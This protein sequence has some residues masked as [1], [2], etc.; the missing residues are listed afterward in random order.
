M[1]KSSS[2][3]SSSWD[4]SAPSMLVSV[5]GLGGVEWYDWLC[6]CLVSGKPCG[7]DI[8]EGDRME[9]KYLVAPG[10]PGDCAGRAA[11]GECNPGQLM[12]ELMEG[13][14]LDS[15]RW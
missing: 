3:S 6:T 4:R 7:E 2:S 1:R 8:K 11:A 9:D 12:V 14:G 10:P 13:E 15:G 5:F